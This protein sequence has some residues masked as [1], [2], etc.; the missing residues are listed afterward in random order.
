MLLKVWTCLYTFL[1]S[2]HNTKYTGENK[3]ETYKFDFVWLFF[4]I[5][6]CSMPETILEP[7]ISPVP[8][9]FTIGHLLLEEANRPTD[10][11]RIIGKCYNGG[12][13]HIPFGPSREGIW[14]QAVRDRMCTN[15][16]LSSISM[17]T[18]GWWQ[19]ADCRLC[20]PLLLV[21][22]RYNLLLILS[23]DQMDFTLWVSLAYLMLALSF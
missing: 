14:I 13:K 19:C 20:S 15:P 17:V 12:L 10:A 9:P 16:P 5:M 18:M 3:R 4:K 11:Q 22:C 1:S 7:M 23:I 8:P 2:Y 6:V 21:H